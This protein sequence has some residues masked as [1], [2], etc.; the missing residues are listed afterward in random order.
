[1]SDSSI[2]PGRDPES[3]SDGEKR[4]KRLETLLRESVRRGLEKGI[5]TFRGTDSTLRDLVTDVKLPKEVVSYVFS[6]VDESKSLMVRM[7]AREVRDF[8][9]AAD[10][11]SEIRRVLTGITFE[12]KTEVRFVPNADGLVPETSTNVVSRRT[13]NK[14]SAEEDEATVAPPNVVDDEQ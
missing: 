13:R 6:Q 1:M 5:G 7:V 10:M 12:I 14:E 8:L 11:S 4:R 9:E 2:P 3:D